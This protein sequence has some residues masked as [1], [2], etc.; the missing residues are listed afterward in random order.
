MARGDIVLCRDT[1]E[2]F[3]TWSDK[4]IEV[5]THGPYVH[6]EIDLGDSFIGAHSDG[7]SR[8]PRAT[9]TSYYYV[10]TKASPDDINAAVAWAETQLGQPYGWTDIFSDGLRFLNLPLYIG[11]DKWM[12]CSDF[13]TRFL[14][15]ARAS[16][17]LGELA[18][19]PERVSPNDL[20]RAFKAPGF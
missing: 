10:T 2:G 13:A 17:P 12:D 8:I 14:M 4:I 19:H 6:V 20:A 18:S 1:S 7:I 5:V 9:G 15:V 16:S 3:H 11:A